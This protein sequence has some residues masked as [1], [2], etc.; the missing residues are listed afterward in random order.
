MPDE[1]T[2]QPNS[3]QSEKGEIL[4]SGL[5]EALM[6]HMLHQDRLV[7][8]MTQLIV[9]I[10]GGALASGFTLR[11]HWL[12]PVVLLFGAVLTIMLLALVVKSELDRDA[13]RAIMDRLANELL[14][15]KI[16]GELRQQGKG[17]PFVRV[18]VTPP[19]W[20][21]FLRGRYIVRGLLVGFAVL[22]TILAGL[23]WWAGFLF[24]Y[25]QIR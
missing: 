13:N 9:V 6:A 22:D 14:P 1:K 4:D 21:G 10:Q 18:S 16:K 24:P 17:E 23:F 5:Y 11:S 7:W 3:K 15:Q 20:Y 2:L 19:R 25:D 8:D 12:G